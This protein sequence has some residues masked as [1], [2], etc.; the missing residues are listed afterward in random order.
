M[1]YCS[2]DKGSEVRTMRIETRRIYEYE[3]MVALEKMSQKEASDI[4]KEAYRGYINS[5]I[6]PKEY[7][8]YSDVEYYYYEIQCAFNIA[9]RIL[10]GRQNDK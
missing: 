6:F 5:Y 7:E 1:V 2:Q 4:L 10:E 8:E 3:D 9:Y